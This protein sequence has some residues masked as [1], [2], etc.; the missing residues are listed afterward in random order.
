MEALSTA[1]LIGN[2]V[3]VPAAAKIMGCEPATIYRLIHRGKIR[4]YCAPDSRLFRIY[5]PDLLQP[6]THN[7][8]SPLHKRANRADAHSPESPALRQNRP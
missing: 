2:L 7:Y 5:L 6:V 1:D 3:T 4:A 8:P